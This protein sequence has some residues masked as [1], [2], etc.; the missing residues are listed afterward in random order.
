MTV[1]I[2][3]SNQVGQFANSTTVVSTDGLANLSK[4]LLDSHPVLAPEQ[5]KKIQTLQ[6]FNK[7]KDT[8]PFTV[9]F[10]YSEIYAL[11]QALFCDSV[12]SKLN[13]QSITRD[14]VCLRNS[15]AYHAFI[16]VVI[17]MLIQRSETS[18]IVLTEIY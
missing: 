3:Y 18:T 1:A 8:G 2:G 14:T 6:Y 7:E 11:T 17:H 9:E 16:G 5:R 13:A 15:Y 10:T 4:L 12:S